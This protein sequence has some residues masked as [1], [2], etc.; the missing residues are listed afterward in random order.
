MLWTVAGIREERGDDGSRRWIIAINL[1][2]PTGFEG[3]LGDLHYD[4]TRLTGLTDRKLM[5]ERA[6]QIAADPEG[7]REWNEY[8]AAT[9]DRHKVGDCRPLEL[10]AW[11]SISDQPDAAAKSLRPA[12]R[13]SFEVALFWFSPRRG[14][15]D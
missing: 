6:R 10:D 15:T 14:P 1:R 7:V 11:R 12:Q 9:R 4:G 2:D 5:R 3:Y 13:A 8:R